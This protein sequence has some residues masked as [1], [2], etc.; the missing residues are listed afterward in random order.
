MKMNN[1][2]LFLILIL[3]SIVLVSGCVQQPQQPP[4]FVEP[5]CGNAICETGN[6]ETVTNC[7]ADC[8]EPKPIEPVCGDGTLES[9]EECEENIPCGTNE[10]CENCKCV[11]D[12]NPELRDFTV[13]PETLVKKQPA[14][15]RLTAKDDFGVES[16]LVEIG[17]WS[18]KIE[19]NNEVICLGEINQEIPSLPVTELNFKI[20]VT[21]SRNQTVSETKTFPLVEALCGNNVCELGESIEGCPEDCENS[22]FL[23]SS[24]DGKGWLEEV[25]GQLVL[26]VSG[27]HYEMGFQQGYLLADEIRKD[28]SGFVYSGDELTGQPP[29]ELIDYYNATEPFI[30]ERF[31]DEM[32]GM[33]DASGIPLIELWALNVKPD[34]GLLLCKQI[35]VWGDASDNGNL[36]H[37]RALGFTIKIREALTGVAAQDHAILYVAKPDGYNSYVNL[38][39]PGVIGTISGINEKKISLAINNTLA[40]DST[41]N[42]M[43][44]PL[45]TKKVLEEASNIDAATNILSVDNTVGFVTIV[46]DG[47]NQEAQ[48]A[49]MTGTKSNFL[50]WNDEDLYYTDKSCFD[51]GL[52]AFEVMK[53]TLMTIRNS[54]RTPELAELDPAGYTCARQDYQDHFNLVK[55]NYGEINAQ[56]LDSILKDDVEVLEAGRLH[57]FVFNVAT[58]DLYITNAIGSFGA[59]NFPAKHFKFNDLVNA[60]IPETTDN[61]LPEL[62]VSEPNS[63]K[64]VGN[65]F[66]LK[67]TAND[68]SGIDRIEIS[69]NNQPYYYLD[70]TEEWETIIDSSYWY[71]DTWN[72]IKVRATDKAG[73]STVKI[74]AIK[75]V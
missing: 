23:G 38:S 35:A 20:T 7:S 37:G 55:A 25:N 31:K 59:H 27:S 64:N 33:A 39:W 50:P 9:G 32:Q 52:P 12:E 22:V 68:E 63:G 71:S 51:K 72:R 74:I 46:S 62:T 47:K 42:G 6:G 57:H 3:I 49:E 44:R 30:P 67:G 43:P 45:H 28:V 11:K 26:H 14:N 65:S 10:F 58:L 4:N 19:C 41:T 8:P 54:Y 5:V 69:L 70:N 40:T 17:N 2:K 61:S 75:K 66:T 48:F 73:N 21:D 53:N 13:N 15:L 36:Y 29:Q 60:S 56:V 24:P 1:K 34:V 16:I 18:K